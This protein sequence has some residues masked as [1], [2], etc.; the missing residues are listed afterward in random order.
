M[1]SKALV[2]IVGETI[3]EWIFKAMVDAI[4][5]H[6]AGVAIKPTER[7]VANAD[8]YHFF[9][10]RA[11]NCLLS[12]GWE[13]TAV[14]SLHGFLP[15]ATDFKTCELAYSQAK[16]IVCVAE[17]CKD[18]LVKSGI[19]VHKAEV[20]HAGVDHDKMMPL[21]WPSKH[22]TIG[23]VGRMYPFHG[24]IVDN[25]GGAFIVETAKRLKKMTPDVLFLIVG[26]EWGPVCNSLAN[27]PV[28]FEFW[29]RETNCNY[30]HYPMLYNR[31]DCLFIASKY[32]GAPVPA[33]E[34]MACGR[35]VV[36]SRIGALPEIV[37][38]DKTGFLIERNPDAAAKAL[39]NI[40]K[41]RGRWQK[42]NSAFCVDKV[43]G[44][45]WKNWGEQHER[46][47]LEALDA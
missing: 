9:R 2:N 35:P 31:M 4:K 29:N 30:D 21:S 32:E 26:E 17:T 12:E 45:T 11:L 28:A 33:Y 19:P 13:G 15:G 41:A 42:R 7:P 24:S 44:F 34:A 23:V 47:Y 40:A 22:F 16:K 36:G 43:K 25:K 8:V 37:E 10:P 38:D 27:I 5:E 46:I 14:T 6:S 1:Q 39:M 3:N 20:V 18:Y